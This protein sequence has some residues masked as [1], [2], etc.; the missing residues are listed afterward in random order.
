MLACEC[1]ANAFVKNAVDD[2]KRKLSF[3]VVLN[4]SETDADDEYS[5][6][7]C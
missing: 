3:I 1:G 4:V 7:I 2:N 6:Y 5:M